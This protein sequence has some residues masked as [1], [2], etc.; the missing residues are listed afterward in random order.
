MPHRAT[1]E[2]GALDGFGTNA[3]E[4]LLSLGL[5]VR[6]GKL[7]RL[8][9]KFADDAGHLSEQFW[10]E[11]G[12]GGVDGE[13]GLVRGRTVATQAHLKITDRRFALRLEDIAANG[14]RAIEPLFAAPYE[15]AE[16]TDF[17]VAHVAIEYLT[18]QGGHRRCI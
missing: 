12:V 3:F 18:N 16:Q 2:Q 8:L 17:E 13:F 10:V 6:G 11:P 15:G 4:V 9:G 5:I 7:Q 14:F 1:H